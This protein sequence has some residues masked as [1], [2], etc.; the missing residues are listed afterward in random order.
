MP[1]NVIRV[2][3]LRDL[4]GE[5]KPR[6]LIEFGLAGLL[7]AGV[8]SAFIIWPLAWLIKRFRHRTTVITP[9][10]KRVRWIGAG[11]V[12]LFG[13]LSFIF[14]AG[15][16]GVSFYAIVS[17]TNLLILS[18]LPGWSGPLFII[19]WLLIGLALGLMVTTILV[20]RSSGWSIWGRLYYT[21]LTL[22][23]LGYVVVLSMGGLMA[24]LI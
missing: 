16:I 14:A 7:L 17:N 2:K 20:W 3:L 10:Q 4:L 12:I 21:F 23:A 1:R 22:A 18:S 9:V 19:P 5:L 15:L 24:V 8:W 11:L 6:A 13:L